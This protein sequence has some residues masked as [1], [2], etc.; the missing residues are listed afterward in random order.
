STRPTAS[1]GGA[2]AQLER[3]GKAVETPHRLR[4]PQ[5][6]LSSDESINPMAPTACHGRKTPHSAR[7]ASQAQVS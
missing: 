5:V 2:V 6:V 1:Q 3:V 4:K 7:T